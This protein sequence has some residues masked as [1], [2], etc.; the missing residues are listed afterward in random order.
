MGT[1]V[2]DSI[3]VM[4]CQQCDAYHVLLYCDGSPEAFAGCTLSPD[5]MCDIIDA[6][7]GVVIEHPK[8]VILQ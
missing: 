2:A 8:A 7:F 3:R 5:M 6:D 1:Q 4:W